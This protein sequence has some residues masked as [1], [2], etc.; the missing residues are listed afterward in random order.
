MTRPRSF[1]LGASSAETTS[2]RLLRMTKRRQ[3]ARRQGQLCPVV[4]GL[5]GE[6]RPLRN[7][8]ESEA[9]QSKRSSGSRKQ[10]NARARQGARPMGT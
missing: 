7:L 1:L 4:D 10:L 2:H 6:A 5:A 8:H 3:Q 9:M